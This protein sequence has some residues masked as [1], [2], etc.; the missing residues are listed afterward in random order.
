MMT[1]REW[2]HRYAARLVARG[3]ALTFDQAADH[4]EAG[5]R[6]TAES[7]SED[8]DDWEAPETVADEDI[9][10]ELGLDGTDW[11]LL[12]AYSLDGQA[13]HVVNGFGQAEAGPLASAEEAAAFIA[14]TA[15]A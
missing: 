13:W 12:T 9:E 10:S 6:A 2:I 4:A 8:L 11:R 7:F 5:C 3:S 1:E 15:T 14:R